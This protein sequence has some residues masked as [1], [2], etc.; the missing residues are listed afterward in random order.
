M[1]VN[2]RTKFQNIEGTAF[3]LETQF[4]SLSLALHTALSSTM[5]L[6]FAFM[7]LT[8][9]TFWLSLPGSDGEEDASPNRVVVTA[10][11]VRARTS[12]AH[13][14]YAQCHRF[15]FVPSS[16]VQGQLTARQP[17]SF[18]CTV[19]YFTVDLFYGSKS[20]VSIARIGKEKRQR[21]T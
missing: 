15:I 5:C 12:L 19:Y 10:F 2:T 17:A 13:T 18:L 6:Q 1:P 7:R 4:V 8:A 14:D 21:G 9:Y 16:A 3:V 11:A 20:L